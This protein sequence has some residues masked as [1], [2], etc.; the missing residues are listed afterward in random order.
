MAICSGRVLV[1]YPAVGAECEL[2]PLV[3]PIIDG[4]LRQAIG[5]VEL[6]DHIL[7]F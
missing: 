2:L 5:L 4:Y 3:L 7:S 1:H 6:V